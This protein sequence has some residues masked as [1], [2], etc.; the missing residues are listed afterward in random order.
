MK[1]TYQLNP[2]SFKDVKKAAIIRMLILTPIVVIFGLAGVIA[3][4]MRDNEGMSFLDA[5]VNAFNLF[6][7]IILLLAFGFATYK[8]LR[9]E[10]EAWSSYE[11][12]LGRD[13][14]AR[15][16]RNFPDLEIHQ[17]EVVSIQES[18]GKGIF[19]RTANKHKVIF[20][21]H[22]LDGY[23]QVKAHLS[24]WQSLEPLQIETRLKLLNIAL[25][26]ATLLLFILLITSNNLLVVMPSGILLLIM[27]VWGRIETKRSPNIDKRHKRLFAWNYWSMATLILF[28]LILKILIARG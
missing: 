22:S 24:S 9:R 13:F 19:V 20:I 11:L 16:I 25:I 26:P 3:M 6:L 27:F 23:E 2:E 1:S 7:V 12:T 21:H 4:T 28:M 18:P 17:N 14:I 15:R 10:R 5:T 8:V